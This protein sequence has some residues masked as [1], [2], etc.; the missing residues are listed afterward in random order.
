MQMTPSFT[1]RLTQAVLL[2]KM[3]YKLDQ[4]K[5][6]SRTLRSLSSGRPRTNLRLMTTKPNLLL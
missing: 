2:V 6:V 5:T 4:R 3:R 1:Y